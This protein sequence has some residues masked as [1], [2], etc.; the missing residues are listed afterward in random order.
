MGVASDL[1]KDA[2][3]G[4]EVLTLTGSV[5]AID[6]SVHV[7]HTLKEAINS[8]EDAEKV[9]A[10]LAKILIDTGAKKILDEINVDRER[11][12]AEAKIEDQVKATESIA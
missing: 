5:T 2:Q 10:K 12:V 11:R 6:G 4:T 1:S 8:L 3:S 7:E 9:G